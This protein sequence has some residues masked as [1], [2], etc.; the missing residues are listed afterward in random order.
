MGFL[1]VLAA[2]RPA[3]ELRSSRRRRNP[4]RNVP[5]KSPPRILVMASVLIFVTIFNYAAES[6]SYVIAVAGVALWFFSQPR[7]TV[8][9]ALLAATFLF[10]MLASTD[11]IPS[12]PTHRIPRALRNQ[13]PPLHSRLAKNRDGASFCPQSQSRNEIAPKKRLRPYF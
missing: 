8:N 6:P 11:L 5:V 13:S 3:L 10:T 7:T 9:L 12:V 4:N 2:P 1:K